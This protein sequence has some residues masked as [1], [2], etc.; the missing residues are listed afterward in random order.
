MACSGTSN[1][2]HR[3]HRRHFECQHLCGKS[4]GASLTQD[5]SMVIL[6]STHESEVGLMLWS[7]C[8]VSWPGRFPSVSRK[9]F[10]AVASLKSCS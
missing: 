6:H 7:G 4:G 1:R 5:S 2:R 3:R 8:C 9:M 10:N